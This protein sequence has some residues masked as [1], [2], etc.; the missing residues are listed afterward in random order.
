MSEL[1]VV[2]TGEVFRI[3]ESAVS[4]LKSFQSELPETDKSGKFIFF[5]RFRS[6][7]DNEL[8]DQR[9]LAHSHLHLAPDRERMFDPLLDETA[10]VIDY[11]P[12][13]NKASDL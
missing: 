4:L 13:L 7:L 2:E 3:Y 9:K 12:L 11:V 10:H 1:S 6:E 5:W 8:S